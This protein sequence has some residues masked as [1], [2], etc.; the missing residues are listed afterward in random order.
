MF[1]CKQSHMKYTHKTMSS[2]C[3]FRM[4]CK[5]LQNGSN[6]NPPSAFDQAPESPGATAMWALR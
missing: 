6:A 4:A 1:S 5:T 3:T 2:L